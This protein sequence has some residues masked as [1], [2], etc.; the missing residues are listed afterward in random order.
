V[1][2]NSSLRTC[3]GFKPRAGMSSGTTSNGVEGGGNAL[4]REKRELGGD[5]S[6]LA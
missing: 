6:G 1:T 3:D 5:T 2:F 4:D